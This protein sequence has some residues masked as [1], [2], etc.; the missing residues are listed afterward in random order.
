MARTFRKGMRVQMVLT[1]A[2]LIPII[3]ITTTS[4]G[5]ERSQDQAKT[6]VGSSEKVDSA[7]SSNPTFAEY[8]GVR[9]GM[10]ATEVRQKLG[11]PK[12]KDK[13]QDFFTIAENESAQ[14]FYDTQEKVYAISI[15]FSGR[16][17][18]APPPRDVLGEDITAGADG[19]NVREETVLGRSLLGFIQSH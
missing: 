3:V 5:S 18:D 2:I 11:K 15:D 6:A 1:L 10:T 7:R 17:N 4:H 12:I 13:A 9:I 8:R 19:S 16:N 14:I